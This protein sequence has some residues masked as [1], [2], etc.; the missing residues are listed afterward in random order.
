MNM[1]RASLDALRARWRA[2]LDERPSCPRCHESRPWHDGIRIRTGTILVDG[3]PEFVTDIPSR[4][5]RCRSC[6]H[7]WSLLPERTEGRRH[8]QPCVVSRAVMTLHEEPVSSTSTVSTRHGCDR[9][10]VRRWVARVASIVDPSLLAATLLATTGEPA[11]PPLPLAPTRTRGQLG[12]RLL[13]A[14]VVLALLEALASA[15]I[16]EPPAL[17]HAPTILAA[18]PADAQRLQSRGDPA[19]EG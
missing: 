18:I 3:R 6:D 7:R 10:T 13:C 8:F 12:D 4:R 1:I 16:L 9:R 11:L 5:L 19:S 17:V 14:V 2:Q 15:L